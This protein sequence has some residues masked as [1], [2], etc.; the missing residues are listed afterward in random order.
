MRKHRKASG[1]NTRPDRN[2]GRALSDIA[3]Q[4]IVW[5]IPGLVPRDA[6]TLLLG[7][8]GCGKSLLTQT[9]AGDVSQQG[10]N[11]LLLSAEDVPESVLVPRFTACQADTRRIFIPTQP[12][13]LPARMPYL[14]A[15][16]VQHN[17]GLLVLDLLDSFSTLSLSHAGN[18]HTILGELIG[19]AR[20]YHLGVVDVVH[21]GK[22]GKR[23]LHR[24]LGSVELA[25]MARS[26]IVVEDDAQGRKCLRHL[27]CNVAPLHHPISFRIESVA[28]G[29]GIDAPR[30]VFDHGA[31]REAHQVPV[32]KTCMNA[33]DFTIERGKAGST[34]RLV[35]TCLDGTTPSRLEVQTRL[36]DLLRLGAF[37]REVRERDR[38]VAT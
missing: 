25:G 34:L 3:A 27:K 18:T 30:I 15:L 16:V 32:H 28:V 36:A 17:P 4:P 21:E 7:N 31:E 10:M 29:Q 9:W 22:T 38:R 35:C 37:L 2:A 24:I 11:T 5:V 23:D 6:L 1:Y 13:T 12:L 26:V 33:E 19:L 20:H 14:R 8:P